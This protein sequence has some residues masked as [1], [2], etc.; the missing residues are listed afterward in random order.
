MTQ[1]KPLLN[2]KEYKLVA[3]LAATPKSIW[4]I[5]DLAKYLYQRSAKDPKRGNSWARNSLRRPLREGLIRHVGPG[6]YSITAAGRRYV[7]AS[8]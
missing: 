3:A 8:K 1:P 2:P 6:T 4:C 7:G 5:A